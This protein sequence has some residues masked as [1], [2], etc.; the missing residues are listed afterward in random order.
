VWFP[1]TVRVAWTLVLAE[2]RVRPAVLQDVRDHVLF[3]LPSG[4]SA[5]EAE[6]RAGPLTRA[7]LERVT[8][9][10]YRR[11]I[12]DPDLSIPVR[13]DWR[14]Q[15]FDAV[16]PVG[17]AVL[18]MHFGDGMDM[19]GVERTAAIDGSAL[20][21]AREGVREAIRAIAHSTNPSLDEWTDERLDRLIARIVG[22][23]ETGCPSP[24]EITADAHRSHVDQCTRCSRAVRLIRGGVLSPSDLV[25][26]ARAPDDAHIEV[27]TLLLHPDGR[28]NRKRFHR[29]I[30]DVAVPVGPD[31]WL[32]DA[33]DLRQLAPRIRSAAEA[34]Q[35]PRHHLRGA[36]VS[37]PGRWS[38][39]V[40][41]GPIAIDAIDA[42]RSRPWS[43]IEGMGELPSPRPPPPRA[44][45]WWVVAAIC[46]VASI[47]TGVHVLTPRGP[48]PS[49][50]IEVQFQRVETGWDIRFD[51]DELAVVDVVAIGE[52]GLELIYGSMVA[53]KGRWA[54][55]EGDF[56]F[57]VASETVALIASEGGIPAL[58]DVV[59]Q[60]RA[61]AMPMQSL[62]TAIRAA[63]PTV[64]FVVS[65]EIVM[66][67]GHGNS[68]DPGPNSP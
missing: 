59:T 27:A 18:R 52:H 44:T 42:A 68:L 49:T 57:S 9:G 16:D 37:G 26:P 56:R 12:D 54:T 14:H 41:L 38:G 29:L 39:Q 51:A 36:V 43:E 8:L 21:G 5:D 50:P 34:G 67:E 55:G 46:A 22:M 64:D 40:L 20:A 63:H 7:Y 19:D 23:S 45:R 13:R 58:I 17:D 31:A 30:E 2:I 66:I 60:A 10:R 24:V 15:L 61:T 4:T 32:L 25:A 1:V 47:A 65:P 48:P 3:S 35:P 6:V 11:D 28:K 33:R 62:E 53:E